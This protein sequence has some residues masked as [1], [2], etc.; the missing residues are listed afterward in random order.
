MLHPVIKPDGSMHFEQQIGNMRYDI[1]SGEM[2]QVISS[3]G[4]M[5]TVVGTNGI[6]NELQ[7]GNLRQ[8][9]GNSGFDTL[10]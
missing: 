10:L 1:T 3:C 6:Q 2:K 4:N 9:M 7:F 8:T 5:R